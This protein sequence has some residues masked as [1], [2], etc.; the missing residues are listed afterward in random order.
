MKKKQEKEKRTSVKV[1]QTFD[2][3]GTLEDLICPPLIPREECLL[4]GKKFSDF[5]QG[6]LSISGS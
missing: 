4:G 3:F 2:I 1:S 5:F 6:M